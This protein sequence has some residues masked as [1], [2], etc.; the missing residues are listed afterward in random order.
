MNH[1]TITTLSVQQQQN[2]EASESCVLRV[3]LKPEQTAD[4]ES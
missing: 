3:L 2:H 4:R 1:T